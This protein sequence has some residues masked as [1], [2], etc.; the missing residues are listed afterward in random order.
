[1][2]SSIIANDGTITFTHDNRPMVVDTSHIN[3]HKILTAI[4]GRKFRVAQ[5]LAESTAVK[6]AVQK[7]SKRVTIEGGQ[8]LFDGNAVGGV[9]VERILRFVREGLPYKPLVRFLENL[10][11]N[12]SSRS[13]TELYSFLEHRGMP[14]TDDGCFVAYKG[15]RSDFKDKWSGTIDNSVGR[16]VEFPRDKVD[17]NCNNTCSFGLHCGSHAYAS[18]WAG[19]DGRVVL[20]KV[21]PADAVAVPVDHDAQKL[22]VMRYKVVGEAPALPLTSETFGDVTPNEDDGEAE[23]YCECCGLEDCE[24]GD[25]CCQ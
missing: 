9:V 24:C 12:P 6:M 21:N 19:S 25:D 10:Q 22:R 15:V 13:V 3:Y 17:D 1:M 2:N 20:V 4:K 23:S 7:L 14:L 8:V 5:R 18:N 16:T 11:A